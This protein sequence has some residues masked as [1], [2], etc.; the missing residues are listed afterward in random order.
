M[1]TDSPCPHLDCHWLLS[2]KLQRIFTKPCACQKKTLFCGPDYLPLPCRSR[3]WVASRRANKIWVQSTNLTPTPSFHLIHFGVCPGTMD[4]PRQWAKSTQELTYVIY[5]CTKLYI[6]SSRKIW[7]IAKNLYEIWHTAIVVSSGTHNDGPREH[8][9][10][11]NT[12]TCHSRE[13]G[14]PLNFYTPGSLLSQYSKA[15]YGGWQSESVSL[16]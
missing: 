11:Q 4:F 13:S 8:P 1:N 9:A 2:N 7:K 6:C 14:N 15:S 16:S 10:L 3:V 12:I 5:I